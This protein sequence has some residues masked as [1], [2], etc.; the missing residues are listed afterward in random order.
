MKKGKILI[1]FLLAA[2]TLAGCKDGKGGNEDAKT[3]TYRTFTSV[4]PSNWNE[5][6]Y[7]DNNDLQILSYVSGAFFTYDFVRDE[8][9]NIVDGQFQTCYDGAKKLED[10]TTTYAGD[11]KFAVPA[12]AT[13][14][15]AYKI[16]LRDDLKW[17]DGTPIHAEDFVYTMKEQLN[18]L[19]LNYRADSFYVGST[20]IHNAMNYVKQGTNAMFDNGSTEEILSM[21]DI[22][23][24]DSSLYKDASGN[25]I[26]IAV[27]QPLEWLGGDR[28]VDYYGSGY[29][30]DEALDSLIGLTET[31]KESELYGYAPLNATTLPII[32]AVISLPQWGEGPENFVVYINIQKAL[33]EMDFSEVGIFV[34]DNENELV[35]VLDKPLDLLKEDGSLSYKAA[36]NF[37]SL[38]LVKKDLFEACKIA[39]ATEG[40]LWTS[41]YN[42][43][44]ETSASWGPYKLSTFQAAKTYE[45][46]RNTNWY[47]YQME[48]YKGQYQTDKIVCDTIESLETAWLAFKKGDLAGIGISVAYNNTEYKNSS[49]AFFT[50]DDYVGS[51]QIQSDATA[52]KGREKENVDKEMLTYKDFRKAISVGLDRAAYLQATSVA[53]KP[54]FGLFNSM[55]YYDVANGGVYRDTTEAKKVICDV[56]GVPYTD[57]NLDEQY[58]TVTGYNPT[59]AKELFNSSYDEAIEAG[60][61]KATDKVVLTVGSSVDNASSRL[62]FEELSRQFTAMTKGTKFEGKVELEF[63]ASFGT[64]WAED[65]RAGAYDLCQGG[66]SGAAWDPGYFLLAYL[67]PAY[68]YSAAWDT[69]AQKLTFNP[70]TGI[71]GDPVTGEMTMSLMDW[72]DYLNYDVAEGLV[73]QQY[74]LGII[75]ALEREIL[76]AYYTV[77][78]SY[79]FTAELVS[80]KIE[81]ATRNYNTF[82]GYGG[83]R[84]M[85][86]NYDDAA[87]ENV[88]TTF[89]YLK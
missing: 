11:E 46:T 77:P 8:Q 38:P 42:S 12:D 78:Y 48:E 56:Y 20:V 55:H 61:L 52:L 89:D 23:T 41:K 32:Q 6:T 16:T 39:P 14:A 85:T 62:N 29:L 54:G 2:F 35:L 73:S 63:D 80:Y 59:L 1:P 75:A 43:S 71:E 49:R 9:G 81:Y 18:P 27:A 5:L 44:V 88:K 31:N 40:G 70:D 87:W 82:M 58:A 24:T 66:W 34:G 37:S 67:S 4:S 53:S 86:Y 65:F 13:S 69:S 3:Y 60:T 79:A 84:Y 22:D 30:D 36:Y 76:T 57:E 28:L 74:R 15:F 68:M 50:G 17:D 19:F 33:P 7:Q 47:G 51:I 64:K 10:V 21:D 25:P 72:Y 26:Y 83:I 45:L